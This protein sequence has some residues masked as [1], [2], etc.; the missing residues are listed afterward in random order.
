MKN[1]SLVAL[2]FM[3]PLAA[4]AATEVQSVRPTTQTEST[5]DLST[6]PASTK[7]ELVIKTTVSGVVGKPFILDGTK[8]QDDGIVRAFSWRLVSSPGPVTL[9]NTKAI[10]PTFTPT[11]AGTYIF[12][13]VVIDSTGLESVVQRS[14]FTVD[15]AGPTVTKTTPPP[16]PPSPS[17]DPDFDL[18]KAKQPHATTIS[19]VS[20]EGRDR[21]RDTDSAPEDGKVTGDP[22][23]DLLNVGIGGNDLEKLRAEVSTADQTNKVTVR[24]WNPKKKEEIIGHPEN[25]KTSEDLKVYVEAVAL[26]D[27]A[28]KDIRIK[29]DLIEVD[30]REE[31]K[32]FWFIPVAMTST[33]VVKYDLS[34]S[35]ADPVSV[36][37]P[38]WRIFVKKSYGSDDLDMELSA[39]L[40]AS[41][42][43]KVDNSDV[44]VVT[45]QIVHALHS[46]SNVLKTKHD[47]VKNSIANVR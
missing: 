15:T 22:D 39:S 3:L 2:V 10:S 46:V 11:V 18:L 16:P 1:L 34:D 31:G 35:T 4:L 6:S 7:S 43:Q 23:F 29:K 20:N 30:S 41:T 13:L 42:E 28:L 26:N 9:S 19:T 47:T 5:A 33:I 40:S 36:R 38:W 45:T 17:G 44:P 37:L 27:E 8:S 21:I 32:L 25:V 14:Q 24:G 12:D